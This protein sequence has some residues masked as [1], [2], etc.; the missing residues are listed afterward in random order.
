M[1]VVQLKQTVMLYCTLFKGT[2]HLVMKLPT[3]IH[4]MA[5][6]HLKTDS[7]ALLYPL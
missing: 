5:V 2:V 3:N 1:V 7:D 4:N 6:V